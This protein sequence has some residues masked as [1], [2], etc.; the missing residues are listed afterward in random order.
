MQVS[1]EASTCTNHLLDPA[2]G[3]VYASEEQ[4]PRTRISSPKLQPHAQAVTPC[5][6]GYIMTPRVQALKTHLLAFKERL[7]RNPA[8]RR[9]AGYAVVRQTLRELGEWDDYTV[10]EVEQALSAVKQ[11]DALSAAPV[12][13]PVE[14]PSEWTS[15]PGHQMY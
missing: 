10:A 2:F 14:P 8:A 15:A 3:G 6:L 1:L 9:A 4:A 13:R 7:Q 12:E 5:I 11:A